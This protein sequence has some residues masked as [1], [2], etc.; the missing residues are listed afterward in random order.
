LFYI[1]NTNSFAQHDSKNKNASQIPTAQQETELVLEPLN[2]ALEKDN[3]RLK[4]D[5]AVLNERLKEREI[6]K[7]ELLNVYQ[8]QIKDLGEE[9]SRLKIDLKDVQNDLKDV[10]NGDQRIKVENLV[11]K[12]RGVSQMAEIQSLRNELQ[13]E[14]ERREEERKTAHEMLQMAM[15]M[16]MDGMDDRKRKRSDEDDNH[17]DAE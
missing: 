3:Q 9:N 10:Q 16:T 15:K 12:E 1:I 5:N 6:C 13:L 4:L 2:K 14:R 17:C 11:L 7:Q 8:S